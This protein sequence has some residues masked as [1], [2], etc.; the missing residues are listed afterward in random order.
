MSDFDRDGDLDLLVT[1]KGGPVHLF[2]NEMTAAERRFVRVR[3]VGLP[4]SLDALGA[5]VTLFTSEGPQRRMVRS[6]CSNLSESETNPVL[7]GLE[8]C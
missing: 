7:F 8:G 5:V 6:G 1:E 2:R 3:L 4:P